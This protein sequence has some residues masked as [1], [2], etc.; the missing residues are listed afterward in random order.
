MPGREDEV[1]ECKGPEVKEKKKQIRLEN[2]R[3]SRRI[4]GWGPGG[5]GQE[6]VRKEYWVQILNIHHGS[7]SSG[8]GAACKHFRKGK[9]RS[10]ESSWWTYRDQGGR[11]TSPGIQAVAVTL[12]RSYRR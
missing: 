11:V 7:F 10:D 1:G 5:G 2:C 4:A 3:V 9:L 6:G 8:N 12:E